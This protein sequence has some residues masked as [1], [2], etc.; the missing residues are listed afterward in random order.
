[1]KEEE[2][3]QLDEIH[4]EVKGSHAQLGAIN[5]R[6]R[7]IENQLERISENVSDNEEDINDL[8]A[9]VKRNTTIVTGAA[10]G[11]SMILLWLSDKISRII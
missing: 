10:G 9:D 6:T 11:M 4:E 1:M 3:D 2:T 5:E 8:E 7:N